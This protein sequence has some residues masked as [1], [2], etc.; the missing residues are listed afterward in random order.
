MSYDREQRRNY[1]LEQKEKEPLLETYR[2]MI[3]RC[4]NEN[5]D[6]YKDYGGRGIKICKRWL[7]EKR[8]FDNF[9]SDM[10]IRPE[11]FTLDRIKVNGDYKPSNCRWASQSTQLK[12]RRPFSNTGYKYI[13]EKERNGHVFYRILVKDLKIDTSRKKLEDA[14]LYVKNLHI[15]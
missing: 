13:Y 14:I 7:C 1:Y 5:K 15:E 11:N 12:N 10:G 6:S 2:S 3:Q 4:Y 9:K 8:G